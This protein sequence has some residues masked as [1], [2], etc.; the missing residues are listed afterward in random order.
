VKNEVARLFAH[1]GEIKRSTVCMDE[2]LKATIQTGKGHYCIGGTQIR[3]DL[4]E[5]FI[6]KI[7]EIHHDSS[8]K[9]AGEVCSEEV[10]SLGYMRVEVSSLRART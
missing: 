10:Y 5:Q 8:R 2:R 9:N 6:G 7:F 1:R 3:E 4:N